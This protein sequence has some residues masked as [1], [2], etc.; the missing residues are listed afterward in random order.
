MTAPGRKGRIFARGMIAAI[1]LALLAWWIVS[2]LGICPVD[3]DWARECREEASRIGLGA[4]AIVGGFVALV[5]AVIVLSSK[6]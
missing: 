4:G 1:G 6:R 2:G 5:T 3:G